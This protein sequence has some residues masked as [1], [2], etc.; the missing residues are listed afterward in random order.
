M[1]IT[2]LHCYVLVHTPTFV[3]C[4][5]NKN[6][7]IRILIIKLETKAGNECSGMEK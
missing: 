5:V 3:G 1:I 6:S 4:R 7:W 2:V